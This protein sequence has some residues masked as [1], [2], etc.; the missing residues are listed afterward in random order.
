MS[1][2]I[3]QHYNWPDFIWEYTQTTSLL[4]KIRNLQG[5]LV[6]KMETLGFD[7][8]VTD[9]L[10]KP[11]TLDR[12]IQ[13][14]E[15]VKS[16]LQSE[17]PIEIKQDIGFVFVKSEYRLERIE[18]DDI[19]FIE[20][21]RD[22]RRIHTLQKKIMTLETFKELELKLPKTKI[23]RVH[24]SYMININRIES[25]E[26]ERIKIKE[27]LIPISETYKVDFYHLIQGK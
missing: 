13:A 20:G 7:L 12:F 23:C 6:G 1:T 26:R 24:K 5:R 25:V 22:Y 9:Y 4:G 16:E 8:N 19:L 11:F 17:F 27:E 14:V 3:H 21:M 2:Y 15:R 18:I 10:L